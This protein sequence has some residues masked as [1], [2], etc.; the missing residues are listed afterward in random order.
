MYELEATTFIEGVNLDTTI[1]I[2]IKKMI[3]FVAL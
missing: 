1:S 2:T 3:I